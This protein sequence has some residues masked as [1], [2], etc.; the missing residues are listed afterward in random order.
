MISLGRRNT[1]DK[2][3]KDKGQGIGKDV[4]RVRVPTAFSFNPFEIKNLEWELPRFGNSRKV[5]VK[6]LPSSVRN[7]FSSTGKPI[8]SFFGF[9]GALN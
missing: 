7:A 3:Q 8:F 4:E 6:R 1:K 5:E 2:R 9:E